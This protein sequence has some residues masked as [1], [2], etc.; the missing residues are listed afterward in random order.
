MQLVPAHPQGRQGADDADADDG[1]RQQRG[2]GVGTALGQVQAR[3]H[4]Y[5]EQAR[6]V[7]RQREGNADDHQGAEHVAEA[8]RH[9]AHGCAG[10][11]GVLVQG[12]VVEVGEHADQVR[13]DPVQGGD[14]T[15]EQGQA[16]QAQGLLVDL[17]DV[18]G[19]LFNQHFAIQAF[20]GRLALAQRPLV[21]QAPGGHGQTADK[22]GFDH[23]PEHQQVQGIDQ[24][25]GEL[26]RGVVVAKAH[27]NEQRH[28]QCGEGHAHGLAEQRGVAV[29]R[30]A[31]QQAAEQPGHQGIAG[32]HH[33]DAEYVLSQ[34]RRL[35]LGHRH[36]AD[37]GQDHGAEAADPAAEE[38][39]LGFFPAKVQFGHPA[40]GE[41]PVGGVEHQPG[42][43]HLEQ[44]RGEV[45]VLPAG[46]DLQGIAAQGQAQA[47]GHGQE[48]VD[49]DR[50]G[51][52]PL[53]VTLEVADILVNLGQARIQVLAPPQQGADQQ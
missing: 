25:I 20:L 8:D 6:Q 7:A 13:P 27:G 24:A 35:M 50:L 33:A 40:R 36:H 4:Q 1:V 42:L 43:G 48:D 38:F 28:R 12:D 37:Q 23:Q 53:A 11:A 52:V 49:Q 14:E 39:D 3:Q 9:H 31:Q 2:G 5:F 21:G 45:G 44:R 22:G 18:Q 16:N 15:A 10:A 34:R 41:Y 29:G 30:A 32:Q 17:F 19:R 51:C 26:E 46:V 47:H